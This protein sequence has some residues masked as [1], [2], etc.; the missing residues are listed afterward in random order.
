MAPGLKLDEQVSDSMIFQNWGSR[1]KSCEK[2]GKNRFWVLD[3]LNVRWRWDIQ[4]EMSCEHLSIRI[5]GYGLNKQVW[6]S[7]DDNQNPGC[8]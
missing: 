7:S 1:E 2:G 6:K 4:T 5:C 8:S 3:T